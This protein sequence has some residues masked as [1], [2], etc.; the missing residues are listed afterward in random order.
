MEITGQFMDI[1]KTQRDIDTSSMKATR[2]AQVMEGE[3]VYED[4]QRV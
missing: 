1:D 4:R 3:A 2:S